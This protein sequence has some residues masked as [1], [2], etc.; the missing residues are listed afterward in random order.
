MT[1]SVGL[2]KSTSD[3][4]AR[5]RAKMAEFKVDAYII[6]SEDAHQVGVSLR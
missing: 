1:L 4:L 6:P 5:L 3:T 2:R